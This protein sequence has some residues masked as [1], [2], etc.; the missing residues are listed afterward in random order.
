M[1]SWKNDYINKNK[2]TRP[3][4]K[5]NSV[6]G[7]I[8]HWTANP[9]A[10]AANHQKYFGNGAGGRYASA[11]IFVD[12]KEALCIV[13]LDE[14]TYQANDVQKYVNGKAYRGA[15]AKFGQNAN[16]T[17]IGVE[18]CV[19][20]N[21]TIS[22]VVEE[23]TVQV[24]ADLCKKF[25][26]KETDI[27][28]HY[29]V[30]GKSCPTPFISDSSRFTN[31]KA[32]VKK[33]L[34]GGTVTTQTSN[35]ETKAEYYECLPS[36]KQV[37]CLTNVGIYN[38]VTFTDATKLKKHH[39]KGDIV[40]VLGVELS[41]SAKTPRFKTKDGYI[42]TNK[43]YVQAVSDNKAIGTLK[44]LVNNLNYYNGARWTKPT[45]TVAKNTV[46]TIVDKVKVDGAYMYKTVSGTYI[47][48]STKYVKYTAK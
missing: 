14:V 2:Y 34:N 19:E 24:V 7:I 23:K 25:G 40:E 6:K 47:T 17:A 16:L 13:P 15:S 1:V 12:A 18:M 5:L 27:Y 26:L 46:L 29:D 8:I 22:S 42:S 36:S 31:F 11:H 28:R 37:K 33:V 43:A 45:G 38:S 3:G 44:V 30:T 10:S 4:T 48:A 32:K 39:E 41:K 9:G 21:G 20:K 35:K